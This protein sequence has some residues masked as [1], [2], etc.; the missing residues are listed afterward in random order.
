MQMVYVQ[1]IGFSQHG[2][3]AKSIFCTFVKL[4]SK[5]VGYDCF[6]LTE[7]CSYGKCTVDILVVRQEID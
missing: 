6:L 1:S 3:C 4:G 2:G 7:K 5:Y